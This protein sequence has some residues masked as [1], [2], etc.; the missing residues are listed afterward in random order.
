MWKQDEKGNWT[1]C[2]NGVQVFGWRQI[3]GKWY[4][5]YEKDDTTKGQIKGNMATGWVEVQEGKWY[6]FYKVTDEKTCNYK[7][8]MATGWL[9]DEG[10]WYYLSESVDS[11][12]GIMQTGWIQYNNRWYYLIEATDESKAEY[13]GQMV[14]DCTRT[15]HDKEY[16]FDSSGAWIQT[17]SLLSAK[18]LDFVKS[19]EGFF[20]NKYYDCVGVLTQ[21]YGMTGD[22]IANLPDLITKETA[23]TLLEALINKKYAQKIKDDLD[24]KGV[25]LSQNEFD[26]LVSFAYNCGTD[27]LL[28]QSTLYKNVVKGVKDADTITANFQA[29][30]NGEGKRIEGLYRRRTKEANM[31]LNADYTGNN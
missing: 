7:G 14:S 11:S 17:E 6:Y 18:G 28:N 8:C 13:K 16:S 21:G 22:E 3:D 23:A 1:Y 4:Y 29:W 24:S 19:F 30:S 26:A 10:H 12:E 27:A 9:Q 31:F 25:S 15:I 20:A 2:I 5:F